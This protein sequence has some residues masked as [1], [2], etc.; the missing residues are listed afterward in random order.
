VWLQK[1]Y[2]KDALVLPTLPTTKALHLG[3]E[4][5]A[6]VDRPLLA[7]ALPQDS[8]PAVM[9]IHAGCTAVAGRPRRPPLR[10]ADPIYPSNVTEKVFQTKLLNALRGTA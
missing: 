4:S 6:R 2:G 7:L 5:A 1:V 8:D 10:V 9:P 3:V